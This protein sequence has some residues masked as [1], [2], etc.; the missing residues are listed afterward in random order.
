MRSLLKAMCLRE[1]WAIYAVVLLANVI[2]SAQFPITNDESY[3][4]AFAKHLQLSYVDAPPFVSYLNVLQVSL[5]LDSPLAARSMV[6]ILHLLSTILLLQIV[7]NNRDTHEQPLGSVENST[8]LGKQLLV[9]FLM[10]YII[11]IFGIF[12]TFILPD[13]GLIV[14]LSIM[15]MVTDK[16]M[17]KARLSWCDALYLGIGLGIGLLSK[18][19]IFPLGGGILLGLF[20]ELCLKTRFEWSMIVKLLFTI[21]IG[22][23]CA[24]PLFI[25]N[26]EHHFAS[27][28]F[29][30]QHGFQ[31]NSWQLHTMFLFIMSA[32][33]YL[34][35][36]F[37]YLLL[38]R[39]LFTHKHW[40]LI[41]P[42]AGLFSILL[43]SSLRKHILP[44]WISPA[45]WLLIPYTVINSRQ[46]LGALKSLM[47][48]C[49]YTA[50]L[51]IVLI[52]IL[53]APGG[54][55][56]IKEASKLYN[57]DTKMF[58]DLL[59]WEELPSLIQENRAL[60]LMLSKALARKQSPQ[61]SV[62]QPIIA[63]FRWYWASQIEYTQLFSGAKILNL[64]QHSTSFYLWRDQW[65]DFA[66]CHVI[67]LSGNRQTITPE[68]MNILTV[69]DEMTIHGLGDYKTLDLELITATL[70]DR[71][72]LQKAQSEL[73]N[74]PHY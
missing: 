26:A 5:G 3:Y 45:F 47:K 68:L 46:H 72:S 37:T 54:L 31:S 14:A 73:E 67:L 42:V 52:G 13:T 34:T 24:L 1:Y 66:G 56:N 44:H 58:T 50:I 60:K 20:I 18:Y 27:F 74:N 7:F 35:P 48:A 29:Q 23:I 49:I 22:L 51:W 39:G 28:V 16:V 15:L 30:F 38:K 25:W 2:I 21:L 63:T 71:D 33:L 70:K 32:T 40:Y 19:H 62:H 9:T 55:Q 53:I 8:T 61:C 64:D 12:G 17:T 41:I 43:F 65:S 59:L 69:H 10:A 6:I 57:T 11:P 36:W 4:I